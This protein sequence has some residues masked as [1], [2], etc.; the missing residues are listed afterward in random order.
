MCLWS[1]LVVLRSTGSLSTGGWRFILYPT[2]IVRITF[3]R[4]GWHEPPDTCEDLPHQHEDALGGDSWGIAY[5]FGGVLDDG[6]GWVVPPFVGEAVHAVG[7]LHEVGQSEWDTTHWTWRGY[8]ERNGGPQE[9]WLWD[10]RTYHGH[11]DSLRPRDGH[12]EW[13]TTEAHPHCEQ[14]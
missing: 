8:S 12:L 11:V 7:D 5:G 2:I 9:W 6:A 1:E 4:D 10:H 3:H 13:Q 14:G